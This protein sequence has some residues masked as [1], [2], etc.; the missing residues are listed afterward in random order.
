MESSNRLLAIHIMEILNEHS[1]AKN[2]MSQAELMER[3]EDKYGD[4]ISRHTCS[5]YLKELRLEGYIAGIRGVYRKDLFTERELRTLI[6]GVMYGKHIPEK[7]A[8]VL[9]EKLKCLSM[10]TMR[11]K[12]RNV[13]YFSGIN[14]TDNDNL[15]EILDIIDEAIEKNFKLKIYQYSPLPGG[16]RSEWTPRIVDPYFVVSDQSRYYLLCN[17]TRQ[18]QV[19][20]EPRRIDRFLRVEIVEEKRMPL[21]DVV[22]YDFD[23]GKY[24][25][26]HI[27]MFS[28]EAERI[29]LR[30]ESRNIGYLI[31]WY[32]PD[33]RV[34][35]QDDEF[36]TV[37]VRA[38][39]DATYYWALQYGGTVEVLYP[40]SL[41]SRVRDGLK[42]IIEKYGG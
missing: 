34:I 13:S 32:G 9:I 1:D 11:S 10:N 36:T 33:Y 29:E 26:E 41:R 25:R 30:I 17:N 38:S 8:S 15:Y 12:A 21:M 39:I 35:D 40:E 18:D 27:Y 3:L 4:I 23:L 5:D 6:D 42:K 22:G 31:D 14:R 7:E 16:D 37:S 2:T 24:M 19:S 20:F 28:G